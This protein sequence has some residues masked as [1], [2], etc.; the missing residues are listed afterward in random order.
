MHQV[1]LESKEKDGMHAMLHVEFEKLK[2]SYSLYF[3]MNL[4]N[5]RNMLCSI[6]S[7]RSCHLW[8]AIQICPKRIKM[9]R[10]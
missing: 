1:Q 6:C 5:Y 2:Q 8:F 7:N 3:F 9:K 10:C 4:S